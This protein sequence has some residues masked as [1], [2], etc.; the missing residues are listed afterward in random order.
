M[1]QKS[2]PIA[3]RTRQKGR[4]FDS[5]WYND[6]D[7]GKAISR[8]Q[9]IEKYLGSVT[10]NM[11]NQNSRFYIQELSKKYILTLF[12]FKAQETRKKRSKPLSLRK[13]R[14]KRNHPKIGYYINTMGYKSTICRAL[15]N[16]R[17]T[18]GLL[19]KKNREIKYYQDP[20]NNL[21]FYTNTKKF[22][23]FLE[24]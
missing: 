15:T 21:Y 19:A 5:S 20:G 11:N 12:Y 13:R 1:G 22:W 14:S 4:F 17:K 16:R 9:M 3:L 10:K 2:N 7:Y 18:I 24:S 8:D 6:I 23:S